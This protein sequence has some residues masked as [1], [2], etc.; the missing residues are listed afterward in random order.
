[1][2]VR[3]QADYIEDLISATDYPMFDL[4]EVGRTFLAWK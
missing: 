4:E 1:L 2:E 3:F